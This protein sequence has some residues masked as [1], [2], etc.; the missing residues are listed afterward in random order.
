MNITRKNW[1]SRKNMKLL[2]TSNSD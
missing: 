2:E 1:I